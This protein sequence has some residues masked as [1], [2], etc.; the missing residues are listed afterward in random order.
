MIREPGGRFTREAHTIA[1]LSHPNICQLFDVGHAAG[2]DYLVM[3]LLQG[4]TLAARLRS[5]PLAPAEAITCAATESWTD[6]PPPIAPA[7]STVT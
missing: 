5:G 1:A 6:S 3:E 7:S 2:T 4:E